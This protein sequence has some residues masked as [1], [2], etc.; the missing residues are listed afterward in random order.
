MKRR[1]MLKLIQSANMIY[2]REKILSILGSREDFAATDVGWITKELKGDSEVETT[3]SQ[4]GLLEFETVHSHLCKRAREEGVTYKPLNL[5]KLLSTPKFSSF[6]ANRQPLRL[7]KNILA[8]SG[9]L[10]ENLKEF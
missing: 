7:H 8:I 4:N 2:S 1:D 5:I 9:L 10:I 6:I 3:K